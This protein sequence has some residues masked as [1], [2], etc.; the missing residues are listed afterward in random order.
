MAQPVFVRGFIG[1]PVLAPDGPPIS[2]AVDGRTFVLRNPGTVPPTGAAFAFNV[3]ASAYIASSGSAGACTVRLW[4]HLLGAWVPNTGLG[5]AVNGIITLNAGN[6][7]PIVL[8]M[9]ALF[10]GGGPTAPL[11]Y[12]VPSFL[13]LLNAD[14]VAYLAIGMSSNND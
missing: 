14:G 2:P 12:G 6:I 13:Q 3:F 8:D 5:S 1:G 4:H 7:F 10:T 11:V 9:A